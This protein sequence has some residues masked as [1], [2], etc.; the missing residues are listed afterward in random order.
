[1][2]HHSLHLLQ[3]IDSCEQ[4]DRPDFIPRPELIRRDPLFSD[5]LDFLLDAG[6][7]KVIWNNGAA[8]SGSDVDLFNADS[9]MLK[10]TERGRS[11]FKV[12]SEFINSDLSECPLPVKAISGF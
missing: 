9:D 11:V 6:Y 12:V 10:I 4:S 3:I 8:D 2:K 7:V 5:A 1:M